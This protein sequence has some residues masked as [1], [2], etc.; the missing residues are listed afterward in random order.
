[1]KIDFFF[2][3]VSFSFHLDVKIIS[4]CF[5][6]HFKLSHVLLELKNQQLFLFLSVIFSHLLN[7]FRLGNFQIFEFFSVIL[8]F[9]YSFINCHK[10]FLALHLFQLCDWLNLDRFN[11]PLKSLIQSLYFIL[12]C[13]L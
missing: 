13:F 1:M 9:F 11:C 7:S 5:Y 8:S 12:C 4:R 2:K 10:F 3:N 6:F